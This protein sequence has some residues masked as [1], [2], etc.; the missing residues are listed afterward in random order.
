MRCKTIAGWGFFPAQQA[1]LI[2]IAGVKVA[3][4]ILSLNASSMYLGFSLGAA[5]GSLTLVYASVSSLGWVATLCEI[6]ALA[7]VLVSTRPARAMAS[8]AP[9]GA[10]LPG[11]GVQ[12]PQEPQV[13]SASTR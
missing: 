10:E 7:I 11:A 6:V 12:C 1:R 2:G 3:P 5:L 13:A 9:V 8:P 4:I